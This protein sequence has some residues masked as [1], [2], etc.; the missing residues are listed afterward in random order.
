MTVGYA[1]LGSEKSI[2]NLKGAND[3]RIA[4][5]V[6]IWGWSFV[7]SNQKTIG[8]SNTSSASGTSFRQM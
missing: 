7:G 8:E 5:P 6:L 1:T 2:A 3:S 4:R